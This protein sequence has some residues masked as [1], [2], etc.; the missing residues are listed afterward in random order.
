MPFEVILDE[1]PMG[2]VAKAG[3]KGDTVTVRV[4]GFL[5]SED[6]QDLINQLE[7][8]P[9]VLLG[10]AVGNQ[11]P[12]SKVDHMLAII[13]RDK[14]ATV[15]IN[16]LDFQLLTQIGR[17]KERGDPI[18]KDDIIDIAR[19]ELGVTVPND[20][21]VFF[22][23]SSGW[24][25]GFFYDLRPIAH[26]AEPR[27]FDLPAILG[28]LYTR[29]VFQERFSILEVQ[30]T[31]LFQAGWFP[32]VGLSN[33]TIKAMLAHVKEDWNPD[34]LL[35]RILEEVRGKVSLF[36]MSWISHP[37]LAAH[38]ATLEKA[39]SEFLAGNHANCLK[40]LSPVIGEIRQTSP[41]L[42][43]EGQR[44]SLLMPHRFEAYL[45]DS[46]F[47]LFQ[48]DSAPV[49]GKAA[50]IALLVIH[51]FFYIIK[52]T[53]QEGEPK[54]STGKEEAIP[55]KAKVEPAETAQRWH[56]WSAKGT[57]EMLAKLI[58]C[59][60]Q[61]LPAGWKRLQ[62]AELEPFQ[63]MVRKDSAWYSLETTPQ[64]VGVTLSIECPREGEMRG[65]RVWFAG[66]PQP[67][68]ATI[69]AAWE[70]V[71][72]FLD[73]GIVPIARSVGVQI[74]A[75]SPE[76]LFLAELPPEIA[77]ALVFFSRSAWKSL[78]LAQEDSQRWNSFVVTAFRAK[79]IVDGQRLAKWFVKEG[80]ASEAAKELSRQFFDQCRL[81]NRFVEEV[82]PL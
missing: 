67:P 4:I 39:V 6:G 63:S 60:D 72:H 25:K 26:E 37:V 40:W 23:F 58:D 71:R 8:Y 76:A 47:P 9:S 59:L 54:I 57:K 16:E 32:F 62:G 10:K 61:N 28:E 14:T 18:S 69:P 43:S 34:E 5:S 33:D 11:I 53:S 75:P 29:L 81:L 46:Y 1:V 2:V 66:P 48:G 70:K 7:Q 22:I 19:M 30:W 42:S 20:A 15:Y 13:R 36:L 38:A 79:T 50:V 31:R 77:E 12:P 56:L 35:P 65:G 80:W 82:L 44:E 78:P 49:D 52:P 24:R 73:E 21:G 51:Q 68:T 64:Y 17:P 41:S 74:S 3:R 55:Q 27:K 45:Q